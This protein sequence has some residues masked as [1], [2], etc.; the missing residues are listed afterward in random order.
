MVTKSAFTGS[1]GSAK[2]TRAR[3]IDDNNT[4]HQGAWA[5]MDDGDIKQEENGKVILQGTAY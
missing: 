3:N 5:M 2:A 1:N 4:I